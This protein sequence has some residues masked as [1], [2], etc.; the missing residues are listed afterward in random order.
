MPTPPIGPIG[1][2]IGPVLP[3]APGAMPSPALFAANQIG[4]IAGFLAVIAGPLL[5]LAIAG[6]GLQMIIT[7]DK[8]KLFRKG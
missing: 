4:H 5:T 8:P 7:G 3:N 1:P 2:E 6:M